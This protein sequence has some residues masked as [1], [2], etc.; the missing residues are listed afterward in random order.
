MK[1]KQILE[2]QSSTSFLFFVVGKM[3]FLRHFPL[4]Q[5]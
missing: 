3:F 5:I 1:K 2:D 4:I